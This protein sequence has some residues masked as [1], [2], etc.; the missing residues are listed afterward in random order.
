MEIKISE[1]EYK[2][3]PQYFDRIVKMIESYIDRPN[4]HRLQVITANKVTIEKFLEDKTCMNTVTPIHIEV[5]RNLKRINLTSS[6]KVFTCPRCSGNNIHSDYA[7]VKGNILSNSFCEDCGYRISSNF[8]F[9]FDYNQNSNKQKLVIAEKIA[10][11][12]NTSC[13]EAMSQ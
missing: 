1:E 2:V 4:P 5:G 11:C 10:E 9:D 6:I 3:N 12:W 13:V 7:I 8:K